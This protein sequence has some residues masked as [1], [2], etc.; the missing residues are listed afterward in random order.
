MAEATHPPKDIPVRNGTRE[1]AW[2]GGLLLAALAGGLFLALRPI[3]PD[4]RPAAGAV[5]L[6]GPVDVGAAGAS[7]RLRIAE[8]CAL[9]IQVDTPGGTAVKVALGPPRPVEVS[10][11]DAPD[12]ALTVAWTVRPGD[13]PTT[14]EVLIPGLYILRLEG[15]G[16]PPPSVG[17][18]VRMRP[19]PPPKAGG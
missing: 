11:V 17:L 3:E 13:R 4:P 5:L 14:R 2:A 19:L 8:P 6:S 12:P 1:W 18:T 10:P 16:A 15:E 7:R 9:E